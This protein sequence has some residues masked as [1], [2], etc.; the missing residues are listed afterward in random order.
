MPFRA[1]IDNLQQFG[2]GFEGI[3][4]ITGPKSKILHLR[5]MYNNRE[6]VN[7]DDHDVPTVTGLLKM[8]L[9]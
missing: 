4:K 2:L 8:F 3:Y 5:K 1:C 7:L 9:R 6:D